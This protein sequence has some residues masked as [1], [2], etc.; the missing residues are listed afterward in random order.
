ML[1][2][3]RT[4]ADLERRL[5]PVVSPCERVEVAAH[6]ADAEMFRISTT[7]VDVS[8]AEA[9]GQPQLAAFPARPVTGVLKASS[10][11]RYARVTPGSTPLSLGCRLDVDRKSTRLNSSH[12]QISHAVFC[13]K[14]K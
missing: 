7:V 12:S 5:R 11:S 4:Q 13:L 1:A 8:C 9:L 3:K 14:Q 2:G 6:S 10:R